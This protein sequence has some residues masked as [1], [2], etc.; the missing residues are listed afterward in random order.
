M[1]Q[2]WDALVVGAGI[3]GLAVGHEL[4]RRGVRTAILEER[5]I[6]SG[7]TQASAGVLAPHIEA[8]D[9]GPL[10][11]MTVRSLALYD[12]FVANVVQDSGARVEYRRT[13]SLE[14]ASCPESERRLSALAR[15][16]DA[17]GVT[18]TW[19]NGAEAKRLEPALAEPAGALLIPVHGYVRVGL[20][21]AALADAARARG[22]AV[23][24]GRKVERIER[25]GAGLAVTVEGETH[26]AATVVVA[27]GSWSSIV[28]PGGPAVT[29]VRGQLL[30]LQWRE[31]PIARILW[32][33]FC[34]VVPWLN[35]TVLVGA[36]VENAGFDQRTT[37]AGVHGLLEAVRRLLPVTAEAT[38]VE[39]R[40]GLRPATGDGLPFVGRSSVL[41]GLLYATGHYR[42]G[43]LLAPLTAQLIANLVVDDRSD[44]LLA[45]TAPDR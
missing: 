33:E 6:A 45:L 41:P 11:E 25:S 15:T 26:T 43:V 8:P 32:S 18:A 29:P 36:T 21:A 3:V 38:F 37:V 1:G 19:M 24:E 40:A 9:E 12:D 17:A 22:A 4:A 44:P 27:A 14:V 30:Q 39:A 16:L 13:G 34:Y 2:Q 42:N 23:L 10:H 5:L 20:L 35:G 31:A 7:A 28:P